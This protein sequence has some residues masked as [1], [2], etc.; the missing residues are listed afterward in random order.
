MALTQITAGGLADDSVDSDA[1]VN[2][3]IDAAHLASGVGV[4]GWIEIG[5]VTAS[6]SGTVEL[7]TGGSP[8]CT[9]A[10]DGTYNELMVKL[11]GVKSANDDVQFFL[12]FYLAGA[13]EDDAGDYEFHTSKMQSNSGDYASTAST[14]ED[15]IQ[16]SKNVGDQTDEHQQMTI[17]FSDPDNTARTKGCYW[18]GTTYTKDPSTQLVIGAGYHDAAVTALTG[19]QFRMSAGDIASGV[20]TIYGLTKA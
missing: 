10:F 2:T 4:Q 8:D 20:F 1:Y 15:S 18:I 11:S 6:S 12:R 3:S 19:L 13:I 17:F 5:S 7:N 9:A 16:L 14:S